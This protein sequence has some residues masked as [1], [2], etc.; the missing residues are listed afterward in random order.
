MD[1]EFV[2]EDEVAVGKGIAGGNLIVQATNQV[3]CLLA[4]ESIVEAL[5]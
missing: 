4:T 1:G 2:V 5:A 3:S